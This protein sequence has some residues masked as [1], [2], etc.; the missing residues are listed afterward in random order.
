MRSEDER[1]HLLSLLFGSQFCK[2]C[3]RIALGGIENTRSLTWIVV[4]SYAISNK[5]TL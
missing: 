5:H 3:F 1:L 2:S 4:G